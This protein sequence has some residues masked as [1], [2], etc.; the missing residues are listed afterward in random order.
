MAS[1]AFSDEQLVRFRLG[2]VGDLKAGGGGLVTVTS[3]P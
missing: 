1:E 3:M 2:T